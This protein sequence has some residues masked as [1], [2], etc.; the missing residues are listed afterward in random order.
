MNHSF[1]RIFS[2][3]FC[4]ISL[5]VACDSAVIMEE[6]QQV[7]DYSWEYKDDKTFTANITDTT[8]HYNIY[9]NLR[10]SFNFEWRNLWVNIETSFPDGRKFDKRVNLV[11]SEPDGHWN[12]DCLGDNCDI[13]IPIQTKAF[14]PLPGKYKFK[15][16]QDMRVNPLNY[17]KSIGMRIEKKQDQ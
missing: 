16:T 14:F 10:H 9:I 5:L 11:V 8:Q 4:A 2:L 7:P 1:S 17:V 3:L 12:G 15:L 13:Q 6:N